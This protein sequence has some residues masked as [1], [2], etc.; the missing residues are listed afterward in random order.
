MLENIFAKRVL[1]KHII[2]TVDSTMSSKVLAASFRATYVLYTT[3]GT[4]QIS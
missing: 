4:M 2:V 3:V 1:D